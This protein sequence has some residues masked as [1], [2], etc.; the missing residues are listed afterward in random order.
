MYKKLFGLL[1]G[2]FVLWGSAV[3]FG[4]CGATFKRT[5]QTC[6][7]HCHSIIVTT[8]QGVGS[9]CEEGTGEFGF[10]CCG[11]MTIDP[12]SCG[13]AFRPLQPNELVSSQEFTALKD[14]LV[15]RKRRT[16]QGTNYPTIASCGD[17]RSA[18]NQWLEAKLKQ[19]QASR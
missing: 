15:L 2:V 7:V 5:T 8:C 14:A 13:G 10:G 12:G 17:N 1:L 18:F 11:L 6:G 16:L 19:R 4:Q 9:V 3:A